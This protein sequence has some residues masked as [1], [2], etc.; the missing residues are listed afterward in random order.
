MAT[1]NKRKN[2][3]QI[4]VSLG[5]D[6]NGRQIRKTTTFKPPQGTTAK[7]AEKLA[8]EF[9]VAYEQKCRGMIDLDENMKFSEL[10]ELYLKNYAPNK[11]KAVTSY[12]TT[13]NS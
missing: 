4:I 1:I 6:E 10:A 2:S 5:Y 13:H 7:K 9:A 12:I 8:N 3:F 11:L